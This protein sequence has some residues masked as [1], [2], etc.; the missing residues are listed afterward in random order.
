MNI[1][2]IDEQIRC[3]I[4]EDGEIAD[5]EQF[6]ALNMERDRKIENVGCWV[7]NLDAEAAAMREEEK[8]LAER[9][10]RLESK[11]E[12]LRAYL[13]H[14]LDGAKFESPRVAISYRK[15][16][17]VEIQDEAVFKAWA[18]DYAP[19]LLKVTYTIDKTG[20]KNYIA[21]GAECPCAVIAERKSMQVK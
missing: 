21:G 10:H 8:T 1:Y 3:L 18:M 12:R 9:R 6:E 20:V 16:K 2:Q 4:N 14:A 7:K 11:A 19:A 5:Y 13:D 17:A 15:S